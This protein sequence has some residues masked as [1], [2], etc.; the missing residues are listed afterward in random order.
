MLY[1][2]SKKV[3]VCFTILSN[4]ALTTRVSVNNNKADLFLKG[5]FIMEQQTKF[6]W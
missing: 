6:V 3:E 1:S 2:S 5:I 4:L